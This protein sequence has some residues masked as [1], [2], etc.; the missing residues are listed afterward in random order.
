MSKTLLQILVFA[1]L[2]SLSF[3]LVVKCDGL[4]VVKTECHSDDCNSSKESNIDCNHCTTVNNTIN[5]IASP[6]IF[7]SHSEIF[8][9]S[10]QSNYDFQNI[11]SQFRPPQ[12]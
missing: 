5:V 8:Y 11:N 10:D 3:N 9:F 2:F 12:A 7:N 6:I 1:S 4:A